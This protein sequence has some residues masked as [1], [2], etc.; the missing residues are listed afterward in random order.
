[1]GGLEPEN[2][3]PYD[4]HGEQCHLVSKDI[5]VYINDSVQLPTNET[6]MAIWLFKQG[7]ISIGL[8]AQFMQFY[9]HGISHPWKILC[10]PYFL[11][12]GVLIVGYGVEKGKPF[13]VIKNSWGPKWGEQGY[14]RLYR[15]KDVCGVSQMATSSL[16]R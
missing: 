13:W 10:E 2:V 12:H 11:D 14:Y 15:G 9:R 7:P 16:I 6:Y 3:Y 8:N 1:M 4:A 5:A